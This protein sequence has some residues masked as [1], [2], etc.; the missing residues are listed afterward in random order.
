MVHCQVMDQLLNEV[1]QVNEVRVY[2]PQKEELECGNNFAEYLRQL[3]DDYEVR[4]F[5]CL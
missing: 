3:M 4:V 5:V 2:Q 1:E